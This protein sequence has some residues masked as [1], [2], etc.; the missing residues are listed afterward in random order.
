MK[1]DRRKHGK[2]HLA[3]FPMSLLRLK[4]SQLLEDFAYSSLI[5]GTRVVS[6]VPN[7][8]WFKRWQEEYGLSMRKANRKYQVPRIV[9]KERLEIFWVVLFRVR[10]LIR[11]VFGYDPTIFNFDQS[12]FHHNET[13]CQDKATLS[14]V[15]SKVPIIEGTADVR[16]R[17]TA[18]L[19]TC[20]R[21]TAVANG[22]MPPA[23]CM[24]KGERDGSIHA[25]LQRHR[26]SCGYPAWFT[27]TVAPK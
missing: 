25:R 27:A 10:M 18:N 12:P 6:F 7:S 19:T 23:E 16:T 20:S 21:F 8:M 22:A 1:A 2:K 11:L 26:R 14:A 17:W 9:L 24:F 13:G 3:R 5:S 15:G 4:V